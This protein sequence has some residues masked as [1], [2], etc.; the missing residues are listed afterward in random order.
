MRRKSEASDEQDPTVFFCDG[1]AAH[2]RAGVRTSGLGSPSMHSALASLRP[3]AK[4]PELDLQGMT[5]AY[6]IEDGKVGPA[7]D[8]DRYPSSA[9]HCWH[10]C[11]SKPLADTSL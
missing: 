2:Q 8:V 9:S 7:A 6:L 4:S 3:Y 1:A 10:R 5:E 11:R